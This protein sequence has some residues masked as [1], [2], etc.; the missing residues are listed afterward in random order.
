MT[1]ITYCR[2]HY[3]SAMHVSAPWSKHMYSTVVP[4]MCVYSLTSPQ[5]FQVVQHGIG[6]LQW[7]EITLYHVQRHRGSHLGCTRRRGHR[8]LSGWLGLEARQV[9]RRLR[10]YLP[11]CPA[12]GLAR[13]PGRRML[14]GWPGLQARQIPRRLRIYRA[15]EAWDRLHAP[16]PTM[17]MSALWRAPQP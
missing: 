5:V 17:A 7:T 16:T 14:S 6:W 9:P 10:I 3:G 4:D 11:A 2:G 15:C 8:M 13:R 12:V 1:H